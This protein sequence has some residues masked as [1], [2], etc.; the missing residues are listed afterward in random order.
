MLFIDDL[1]SEEM[2][3]NGKKWIKESSRSLIQNTFSSTAAFI[4]D[5]IDFYL[6]C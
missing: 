6:N 1:N 2:V 5:L 4:T 3:E